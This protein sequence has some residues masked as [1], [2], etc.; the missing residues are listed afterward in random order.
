MASQE[1]TEDFR[2]GDTSPAPDVYDDLTGQISGPV[3]GLTLA[4]QTWAELNESYASAT[5][6]FRRT[7]SGTFLSPPAVSAARYA[8]LT[9][10]GLEH[11]TGVTVIEAVVVPGM[12]LTGRLDFGFTQFGIGVTLAGGGTIEWDFSSIHTFTGSTPG[13]LVAI[14]VELESSEVRFYVDDVLKHTKSGGVSS[15]PIDEIWLEMPGAYAA[16]GRPVGV[17]DLAMDGLRVKTE[18]VSGS[19]FPS[20]PSGIVSAAGPLGAP[21]SVGVVGVGAWLSVPGP[22]GGARVL[23]DHDFAEH[24]ERLGATTFFVC[25]LIDGAT[26]TR[27]PISSWQGTAQLDGS[28]Y[29]QAVIPGVAG[30]ADTIGAL[31]ETAVFAISRGAVLPDGTRVEHEVGRSLVEFRQFDQGPQ[32]YTCTLSGYPDAAVAPEGAEPPVRTLRG[33]RTISSGVG[34]TRVR[35]ALDWFL[36]PGCQATTGSVLLTASYINAYGLEGDAYMDVGGE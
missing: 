1:L 29:L 30:L 35:C 15:V 9:T 3:V 8:R 4:G 32:R 6:S 2:G 22:L 10:P 33:V 20:G 17:F 27:V 25:D 11:T 18:T 31:S 24:L 16:H 21:L 36:K 7:A 19:L 5:G 14:R 23:A 13:A 34:G 28:G 26:T 12:A